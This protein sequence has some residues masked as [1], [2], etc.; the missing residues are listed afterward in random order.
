[1]PEVCQITGLKPSTIYKLLKLQSFPTG[2]MLTSKARGWPED[3]LKQWLEQRAE[4]Q[5]LVTT[6]LVTTD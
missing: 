2:V 4:A 3:Q 5:V 1:M 6:S